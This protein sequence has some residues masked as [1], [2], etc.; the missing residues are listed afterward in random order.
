[1]LTFQV[2][3]F[4]VDQ[5][6]SILYASVHGGRTKFYVKYADPLIS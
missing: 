2:N 4:I 1:M 3:S 5:N 6:I